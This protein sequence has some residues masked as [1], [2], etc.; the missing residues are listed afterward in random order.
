M[1]RSF[2]HS[3]HPEA[4]ST[5]GCRPPPASITTTET[6][7]FSSPPLQHLLVPIPL[8][9]DSPGATKMVDS[10]APD[11]AESGSEDE[12]EDCSLPCAK[13]RRLAANQVQFLE[14]SFEVDNKL[15]PERKARLAKQLGLQ[16]RQVTI[17][18]QNRRA[19]Y[20]TKQLE[21]D[22]DSLKDKFDEL[23]ADYDRLIREG[24]NLRQQLASLKEKL[25]EREREKEATVSAGI[26]TAK[27]DIVD[28]DS[29]RLLGDLWLETANSPS[30]FFNPENH[31]DGLSQDEEEE[32]FNQRLRVFPKLELEN[33]YEDFQ[34]TS[35]CRIEF[36]YGENQFWGW[37]Y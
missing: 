5:A 8:P 4:R 30:H 10:E 17:W 37:P 31:S 1:H 6:L 2:L 32:P 34:F 33:G 11:E 15:E 23:R 35:P 9:A 14:R 20:K 19:R 7:S 16:P 13:K 21:K 18:F 3:L 27:S 25:L 26:G 22:Y 36:S 12:H 24:D 29:P 28:S